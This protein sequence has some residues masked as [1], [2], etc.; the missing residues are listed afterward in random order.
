M[1]VSG[2]LGAKYLLSWCCIH[3]SLKFDMQN[4][5]VLKKSNFD[6]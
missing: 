2:S 6:V 3:D 5:D 1:G 4:D